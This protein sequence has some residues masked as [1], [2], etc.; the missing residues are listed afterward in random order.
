M[1]ELVLMRHAKSSWEE[2]GLDDHDRPL[3]PRGLR[4]APRMGTWLAAEGILPDVCLCSSARRTRQTWELAVRALGSD[5]ETRVERALYL[6]TDDAILGLLA[7]LPETTG[8]AI[9]VG[10]NPGLHLLARRLARHGGADDRK[11]LDDKMPTGACAHFRFDV[12][13]VDLA[14]TDGELLAYVRPKDLE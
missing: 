13:W 14:R 4:A 7:N 9:V 8:T 2:P 6:A 1:V 11:R 3:T 5:V 12:A 10:H